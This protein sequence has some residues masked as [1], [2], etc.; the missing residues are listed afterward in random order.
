M[1]QMLD[2][3][4]IKTVD[5]LAKVLKSLKKLKPKA[6]CSRE[7][8]ADWI[9]ARLIRFKYLCLKRKQKGVV[10]K[11]LK[12]MTGCGMR[13]INN[14][15]AAYKEGK[16]LCQDYERNKF[17]TIYTNTD[18]EL[19]AET[20]NLHGRLNANA[21]K[22]IMED[23]FDFG[24]ESYKRLSNISP[25]HI[26]N[27]R[28]TRRY[29]DNSQVLGET[30]SVQRAIGERRK[31]QPEGQPG[32]LRVDTVHQ[33]DDLDGTKGLYH[34]NFVDEVTQWQIVVAVE[35]ISEKFL[36]PVLEEVLA[37][38]PFVIQNFHS[39]NGSEF[40]NKIVHQ[41]LTR[42]FVSQT[43]SRA[44]KSNDNAL[45]EGKNGSTIRKHI[46]HWHID[47]KHVPKLNEFYKNHFVPYLNY[48]RPCA[49]PVRKEL[50]NGKVKID[51]PIDD[52]MTPLKKLMS[53]PN[54]E[55]FL[56]KD[57]SVNYLLSLGS[58]KSPNQFAKDMLIAKNNF[59]TMALSKK[60]NTI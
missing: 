22:K 11:Y 41:I 37:S 60:F 15:I 44:R 25:A 47:K 49:F 4:Y 36:A 21:T 32:F 34:I 56:C 3:T 57:I 59:L 23:E 43:K 19:L 26:Y 31:P 55:K 13:T 1:V 8:R 17:P 48:Y 53:I 28:K 2:D 45:C 38:F 12:L 52:Y 5:E 24:D 16:K 30:Q 51:Y 54:F 20:D 10:I 40:I 35:A 9:R 29:K 14:H 46:G 42:L 18:K 27:L 7:E 6:L 58:D 50:A 33:G 39:D